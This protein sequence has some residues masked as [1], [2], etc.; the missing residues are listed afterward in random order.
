MYISDTES[1]ISLG[2]SCIVEHNFREYFNERK[3]WICD[4][5]VTTLDAAINILEMHRD[6]TLKEALCNKNNYEPHMTS[7]KKIIF[8]NTVV[9]GFSLWHEESFESAI[10][11]IN[12]VIDS[13]LLVKDNPIFVFL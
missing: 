5:N 10:E 7:F 9:D 3:A 13:I 6:G 2:T 1:F 11:K 12:H 8:K 4:F